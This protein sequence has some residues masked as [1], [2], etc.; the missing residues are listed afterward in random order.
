MHAGDLR[1]E[2]MHPPPPRH[3]ADD[4]RS[5]YGHGSVE[6]RQQPAVA[7]VRVSTPKAEQRH[8]AKRG[9]LLDDPSFAT[10]GDA[11]ASGESHACMEATR[12]PRKKLPD[13]LPF[14]PFHGFRIAIVAP[15]CD[16]GSSENCNT[17]GWRSSAC[18]TMARWTPMP[19]PWMSRTSRNP[20][21]CAAV[22]YSSTT[23]GM[24]RGANEWRSSVPSMGI[25]SGS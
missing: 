22:T 23:D 20:A 8:I 18:C 7:I 25:W 10:D 11:I 19:R 2:M 3:R 24:S 16:A 9:R 1:M 13:C 14:L 6:R 12:I 21:V 17:S 15:R 5:P 4:W